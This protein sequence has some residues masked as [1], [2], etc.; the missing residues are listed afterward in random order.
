MTLPR[1]TYTA[2]VNG[3][4]TFPQPGGSK[5]STGLGISKLTTL[6]YLEHSVR[7]SSYISTK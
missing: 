4:H 2:H 5:S 7:T 3:Y 1:E 6:P